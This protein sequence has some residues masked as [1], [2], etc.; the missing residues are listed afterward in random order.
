MGKKNIWKRGMRETC[1]GKQTLK[2]RVFF[3][4]N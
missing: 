1:N 2:G 3:K 4:D